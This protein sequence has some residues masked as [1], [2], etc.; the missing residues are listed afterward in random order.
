MNQDPLF[1][2]P[3]DLEYELYQDTSVL[4]VRPVEYNIGDFQ[5]DDIYEG[6]AYK[7][8]SSRTYGFESKDFVVVYW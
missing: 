2:E 5:L 3:F 1:E 7:W 6:K 4:I 8:I